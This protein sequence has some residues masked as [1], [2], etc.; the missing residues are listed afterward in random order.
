MAKFKCKNC[1]NEF[2]HFCDNFEES[3]KVV[4]PSCQSHWTEMIYD[5][6]KEYNPFPVLPYADPI[7]PVP[8][9]D[10]WPHDTLKEIWCGIPIIST[11]R[12][13]YN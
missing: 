3:T 1:N 10:P 6:K 5:R 8:Y 2:E 13:S 7:H 12:V 9:H 4:C 11:V